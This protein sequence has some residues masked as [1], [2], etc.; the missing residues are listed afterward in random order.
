MLNVRNTIIN[1]GLLFC[2][3]TTSVTFAKQTDFETKLVSLKKTYLSSNVIMLSSN[4]DES[5]QT[6]LDFE[7]AQ[8][9]CRDYIGGYLPDAKYLKQSITEIGDRLRPGYYWSTTVNSNCDTQNCRIQV[10]APTLIERSENPKN[11][12]GDIICITDN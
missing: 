11:E 9:A 5:E 7:T 3:L 12:S 8:N 10:E 6:L 1:I 4:F 2:F